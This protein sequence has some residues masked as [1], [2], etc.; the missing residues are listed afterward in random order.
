MSAPERLRSTTWHRI[1]ANRF[2]LVT[3]HEDGI[4][5]G[6][7]DRQLAQKKSPATGLGKQS[8]VVFETRNG[9]LIL[10]EV[11]HSRRNK[12]SL[13]KLAE[14]LER[15]L[16][17]R[18]E[19]NPEAGITNYAINGHP[20]SAV[21]FV[22]APGLHTARS[23]ILRAFANYLKKMHSIEWAEKAFKLAATHITFVQAA[24]EM[25][26]FD[27]L[28]DT[29]QE[30]NKAWA[31]ATGATQQQ[32]PEETAYSSDD[33]EE[34]YEIVVPMAKHE[35]ALAEKAHAEASAY[36]WQAEAQ[37]L[38][39]ENRRQAAEIE[40]LRRESTA[41]GGVPDHVVKLALDAANARAAKAEAELIRVKGE[42]EKSKRRG[43]W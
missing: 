7:S 27:Y 4:K 25:P 19:N 6:W 9:K 3:L 10:V 21:Y 40:Q 34:E 12:A 43:F 28:T 26:W 17:R 39:C 30:T 36:A 13:A 15:V 38:A 33:D 35:Q 18:Y 16:P 31:A 14:F 23:E 22:M 32:E 24:K 41:A 8:D 5:A 37:R 42:A 20:V 1:W 11:E 2:L 29:P